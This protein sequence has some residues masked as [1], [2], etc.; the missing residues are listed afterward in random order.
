MPQEKLQVGGALRAVRSAF[1]QHRPLILRLTI[2][3]A[4]LNAVAT[5]LDLTGAA[6]LALSFGVT[7]LLGAAYSGMVTALICLPGTS[8]GAAELWATVK[9]VLARLIWVTLVTAIALVLGLAAL[10]I[11]G[12]VIVTI[13][14]VAGQT[15]VV[16]RRA[17]FDSLG[18]SF[19]LVKNSG[20]RV[21]G[22]LVV[23]ALISLLLLGL[24]LLVSA[25]LGTGVVGRLIGNFLSNLLSTPVL[26]IG[27]A[28]LYNQLIEL[29]RRGT[30]EETADPNDP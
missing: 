7:I 1:D 15:V 10:V 28:V 5:L 14:S 20:M 11:P 18:R 22:Y 24:A 13:W 30:G 17:V 6:G 4:A 9:P 2:G 29:E 23:I 25:P 16:E 12:L 8:E 27:S 19:D 3:F 26:A 21:F